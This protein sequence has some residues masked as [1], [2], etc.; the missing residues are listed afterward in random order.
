MKLEGVFAAMV[1][2]FSDDGSRISIERLKNY[3]EFL[4]SRGISGLFALGTTGEWPLLS[5]EER[6]LATETLAHAINGRVPLIV[7][8]GANSTDVASG[9]ARH[10]R[11]LGVA[12]V[13]IIAP[14]FYPLDDDAL[15]DHFTAVA[16][17]VPDVPV[18]LYNIPSLTLNDITPATVLRAASL[19]PNIIGIKY[20]GDDTLRFRSYRRRL[21]RDFSLF[22]GNDSMASTWLGEGADGLVSGNASAY[23]EMLV[24]LYSAFRRGGEAAASEPQAELDEIIENR[25]EGRELSLFKHSLAFRGVPVGNVRPPLRRLMVE[26]LT[27]CEE[28]ITELYG[29]GILDAAVQS[30]AEGGTL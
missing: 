29:R 21:G 13:S 3:V 30:P 7:H 26:G 28:E 6:R 20:S 12:A 14:G 4:I 9:L 27:A 2:P 1:T 10:A 25:D 22:C 11:G 23:P 17:S 8:C 15:V 5:I 24:R 18:F 19:N 16:R